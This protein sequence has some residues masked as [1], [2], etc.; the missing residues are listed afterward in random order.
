MTGMPREALKPR[1]AFGKNFGGPS[2]PLPR[3]PALGRAMVAARVATYFHDI[4]SVSFTR[5]QQCHRSCRRGPWSSAAW[6]LAVAPLISRLT[7]A[8]S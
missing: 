5:A 6:V 4:P 8:C 7:S 2:T 1:T 3:A